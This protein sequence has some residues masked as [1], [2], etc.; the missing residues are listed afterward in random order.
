MRERAEPGNIM[1]R[2]RRGK[3]T[4][5]K[6]CDALRIVC[7]QFRVNKDFQQI[8]TEMG[9]SAFVDRRRGRTVSAQLSVRMFPSVWIC[10]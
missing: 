1:G 7:V 5:K 4:G 8:M 2:I 3:K 6:S 9:N 10:A